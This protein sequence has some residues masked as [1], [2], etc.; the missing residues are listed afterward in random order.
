M[1]FC[2]AI[3][4]DKLHTA[5]LVFYRKGAFFNVV[6]EAMR[7]IESHY[8]LYEFYSEHSDFSHRTLAV[9]L[10]APLLEQLCCTDLLDEGVSLVVA[11]EFP[12]LLDRGLDV[13]IEL[14]RLHDFLLSILIRIIDGAAGIKY[15][16]LFIQ[17]RNQITLVSNAPPYYLYT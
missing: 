12:D 16:L 10:V 17:S 14:Y 15:I 4:G 11:Q 6:L 1:Y 5:D 7:G 8:I 2:S 9:F 13:Y 3:A